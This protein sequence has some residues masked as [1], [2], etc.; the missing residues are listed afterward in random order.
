MEEWNIKCLGKWI[1]SSHSK[2]ITYI[3][4]EYTKLRIVSML[5]TFYFPSEYEKDITETPT[6]PSRSLLFN[7]R[8]LLIHIHG[9]GGE[10]AKKKRQPFVCSRVMPS[11][12]N[13]AAHKHSSADVD[14][15]EENIESAARK[16][17]NEWSSL[18]I[19]INNGREKTKFKWPVKND[20]PH[21]DTIET[22]RLWL[23]LLN[24][25]VCVWCLFNSDLSQC[26]YAHCA[27]G[28]W[29]STTMVG[30][31][32]RTQNKNEKK[33][34]S[35]MRHLFIYAASFS[36][37]RTTHKYIRM[38]R[39]SL[40]FHFVYRCLISNLYARCFDIIC[41]WM[42]IIIWEG[43]SIHALLLFCL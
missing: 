37:L 27:T 7:F 26:L 36:V 29:V 6:L 1:Y 8:M 2:T 31:P 13:D 4:I 32:S 20:Q 9:F 15:H 25:F 40:P 11:N 12:R 22:G 21:L 41:V 43:I 10:A 34:P 5:K 33:R 23:V 16:Q 19:T 17:Y 3:F 42:C 30:S 38:Y 18:Y 35:A 14:H 28:H 24:A 39:M